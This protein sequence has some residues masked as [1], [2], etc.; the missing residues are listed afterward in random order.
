MVEMIDGRKVAKEVNAA[1]KA[2]VEELAKKGV[3]PGLAVILVGD[4]QASQRYVHM[5]EKKAVELGINSIM[6][7]FPADVSEA[8]LIDTI[9]SLNNDSAVNGILVQAPLPAHIDEQKVIETIKPEKD[10]DGFHPINVGNLFLNLDKKYPVACTPKGIMTLLEKYNVNLDGA[11]VVIVGRS[12]I[13]G[14]P[15][16]A[17]ML[18]ANA[19]VTDVHSHTKNLKDYTRDADV[20]VSAVGK[21]NML[22]DG[23]FKPGAYVIDVGQ[24][25]DE[26]GKLVGDV[27]YN[28][29]TSKIGYITPVPGGVGPMTIATL[30]QQTV[31][32]C[33]WSL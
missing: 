10:V 22:T 4:N 6:K 23:D 3:T 2:K 14:K 15:M 12:S 29:E 24:N 19:T 32:M 9:K 11:K 25:L 33:E 20:V 7:T 31:E 13:V 1:T 28:P 30:M 21:S 26:N 18:N 16:L 5:K 8:T 27:N 17:L